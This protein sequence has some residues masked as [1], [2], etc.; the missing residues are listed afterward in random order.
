MLRSAASCR[1]QVALTRPTRTSSGCYPP[2]GPRLTLP[3]PPVCTTCLPMQAALRTALTAEAPSE[4]AAAEH[5]IKAFCRANPEGQVGSGDGC[6]CLGWVGFI[7]LQRTSLRARSVANQV[8][9]Q[10][11][12]LRGSADCSLSCGS[13]S[14]V[15][16]A[17]CII[18]N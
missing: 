13:A 4:R 18:R 15:T 3:G 7:L 14:S 1:D 2:C 12:G 8:V 11:P 17:S 9:L 6:M 10:L 16:P 5:L